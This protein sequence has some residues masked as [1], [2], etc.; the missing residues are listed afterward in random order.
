MQSSLHPWLARSREFRTTRWSLLARAAEADEGDSARALS[1]LCRDY[2]NPLYHFV[3]RKGYG[4]EESK[5]L[6]QAFFARLV[7]R[8]DLH[9]VSEA[10]GRFRTFL[11]TSL[12][13]FLSNHWRDS[14]RQK[15]G[16]HEIVLSLHE[17]EDLDA[18]ADPVASPEKDYDRQWV[19]ALLAAVME[20]LRQ[21]AVAAGRADAFQV[22]KH[23]LVGERGSLP[24]AEAARQLRLTEAA[25]KA[26]VHRMRL[27]Y[28]EL[29]RDE[30]ARTLAD[31]ADLEDEIR[32]LLSVIS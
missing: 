10:R 5:D 24:Y 21:E 2:W 1:A 14:H 30:V 20:R 32:H 18:S 12:T 15:R 19:H 17:D 8:Q 7:E 26:A 28:A 29:F 16:G 11:L 13:H 4:D 25:V 31:Q 3:R 23:Y 27:R 6:T 22:M 9:A